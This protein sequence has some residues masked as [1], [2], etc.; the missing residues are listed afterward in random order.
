MHN[1]MKNKHIC[2]DISNQIGL[3]EDGFM[4]PSEWGDIIYV[5]ASLFFSSAS[6]SRMIKSSINDDK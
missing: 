2:R 1:G 4:G 5:I 3:G 6:F